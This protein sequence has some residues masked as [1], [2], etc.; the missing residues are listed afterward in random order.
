[1]FAKVFSQIFDSSIADNP[2]VRRMFMDLLVLSDD[3]GVIDATTSAIAARTRIPIDEVMRCIAELEKP[4]PMSRTKEMDGRRLVRLDENRSWGWRI[5]NFRKYREVASKAML[6]MS[7]A[8]RKRAY[9]ER[10]KNSPPAPPSFSKTEVEREAEESRTSGGHVPD[11][12]R[13]SGLDSLAQIPSLKEVIDRGAM[14][15]VPQDFCEHYHAVCTERHRWLVKS[16]TGEKV[17]GW[18]SELVRWWSRDRH[19]WHSSQPAQPMKAKSKADILKE[20]L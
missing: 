15:G 18:Q 11:M 10:F 7:E 20:V 12:S 4:D 9:R 17:I 2:A 6:R 3:E 5:V 16:P 1:M 14:T 19:N 13:K 8:D